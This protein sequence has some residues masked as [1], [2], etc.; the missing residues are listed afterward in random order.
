LPDRSI[1]VF[2]GIWQGG[3]KTTGYTTGSA[4]GIPPPLNRNVSPAIIMI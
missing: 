2:V 4:D 1:N 3:K